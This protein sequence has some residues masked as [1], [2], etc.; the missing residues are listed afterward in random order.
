M[1]ES[2]EIFSRSGNFIIIHWTW[3]VEWSQQTN[4][5]QAVI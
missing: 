2:E 5:G 3:D 1:I 4:V